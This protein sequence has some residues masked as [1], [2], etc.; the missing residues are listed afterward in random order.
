MGLCPPPPWPAASLARSAPQCGQRWGGW[1]RPLCLC[2]AKPLN[3]ADP[4][5]WDCSHKRG[6]NQG[7]AAV[8]RVLSESGVEL[9]LLEDPELEQE[10]PWAL[11]KGE[12]G[13]RSA[14]PFRLLSLA[15][16]ERVRGRPQ[17]G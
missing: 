15:S 12:G 8:C 2:K 3:N 11:G 16:S 10:G 7:R 17:G 6:S 4:Q 14:R 5:T 1:P 9:Q 13:G